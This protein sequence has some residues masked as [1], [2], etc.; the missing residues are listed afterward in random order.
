MSYQAWGIQVQELR[1]IKPQNN[2]YLAEG[3]H[4]LV[5]E[6]NPNLVIQKNRSY[7]KS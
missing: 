2:T 7:I 4:L 1:G 5:K 3:C 6:V